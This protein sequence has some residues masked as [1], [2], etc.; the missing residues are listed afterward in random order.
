MLALMDMLTVF[1]DIGQF[2]AALFRLITGYDSIDDWEATRYHAQ[3]LA[4]EAEM[5]SAEAVTE[6]VATHPGDVSSGAQP[7]PGLS[8]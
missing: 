7:S 5:N 6:T 4:L 2:I 8:S 1:C 3:R